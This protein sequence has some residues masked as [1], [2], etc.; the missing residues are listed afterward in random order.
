MAKRIFQIK[1][2]VIKNIEVA[3]KYY[4][5]LLSCAN[6]AKSALPGHFISIKANNTLEPLLRRPFGVH[7]ASGNNIELLYEVLGKGTQE[8]SRRKAGELLDIIGPLGTGFDY[9][10]KAKRHL[11][12]ILVAGGMGVAPLTFLAEKLAEFRTH[13]SKVKTIVLL[14]AKTKNSLLCEQEFNKSGCSVEIATDD[15]SKGFKGKVTDL[16][17]KI[18]RLTIHYEPLT[19]YACGPKPMLKEIALIAKQHDIPAQ[20]SLEAHMAC[21]IGACLGCVI[22]TREGYKRV[23]KEGPVFKTDEV[24][25]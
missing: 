17:K 4:K 10:L 12:P 19:I 9:P 13:N 20:V 15:G 25:W 22:N 2:K 14:G 23:C 5:I 18:L 7:R 16:L 6:I 21:G 3:P 11:L 8:L 1:A 24:I